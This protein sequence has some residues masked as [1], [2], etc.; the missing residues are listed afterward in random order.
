MR[1]ESSPTP[2]LLDRMLKTPVGELVVFN[3]KII[4]EPRTG[5]TIARDFP[6][7]EAAIKAAEAMNEVADWVGV[8]KTRAEGGRPNCQDE[9]ERIVREHGGSMGGKA[10]AATVAKCAIVVKQIEGR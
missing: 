8:I 4:M 2:P 3:N 5:C 7:K 9:I 10:D 6:N 1:L